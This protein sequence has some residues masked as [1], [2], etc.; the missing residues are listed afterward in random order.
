[1]GG[2]FTGSAPP[3]VTSVSN[4]TTDIPQPFKDY[5]TG[6]LNTGKQVSDIPYQPYGGQRIAD[7]TQ[8]Q[9]QSFDLTQAGIGKYSPYVQQAGAAAGAAANPSLD[10]SVFASYTDPYQSQVVDRIAQLGQRNL[11]ENLL[12]AVN[13]TFVGNGQFGSS[14]NA[15]FTN[16]ALRDT[17]ESILGQQAQAL[18]SGFNTSLGAY[19]QAQQRQLGAGQA[20]AG[21]GGAAQ[22][23]GLTDAASLQ[24]IGQQQQQLGQSNLDTAYQD[25]LTQRNYPQTQ[26]QFLA[27]LGKG[28]PTP[29]QTTS[30]TTGPGQ[31]IPSAASQLGGLAIGGLGLAGAFGAF[32]ARGGPVRRYAAGGDVYRASREGDDMGYTGSPKRTADRDTMRRHQAADA[33]IQA[34]A[35]FARQVPW[36]Q[37]TASDWQDISNEE[38]RFGPIT[39]VPGMSA[40]QP[41]PDGYAGGGVV[42]GIGGDN[43]VPI[44]RKTN[45]VDRV[46][47]GHR[48]AR[49][50]LPAGFSAGAPAAQRGVG[51]G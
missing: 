19:G 27:N 6:L 14:R 13:Q 7:F 12:P 2:L 42:S 17:N 30:S 46:L 51:Y 48:R 20:L 43:V 35:Y 33:H 24:A 11:S 50:T 47:T 39:R 38:D 9:Q 5:Y 22:G 36:N 3:N 32:K 34:R 16:R 23:M 29:T 8:P 40:D 18:E 1:M 41:A 26:T 25:F 28:N 37:R 49:G 10:P 21:I 4:S 31:Y 15:D 44:A 45:R